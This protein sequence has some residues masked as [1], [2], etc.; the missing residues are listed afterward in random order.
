MSKLETCLGALTKLGPLD[1]PIGQIAI[2]KFLTGY[3]SNAASQTK[4]LRL[5]EVSFFLQAD[6]SAVADLVQA[7][8]ARRLRVLSL[9][10]H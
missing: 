1:L 7:A 6:G 2:S 10:P 5:L 4:G 8:I 9:A 3:A